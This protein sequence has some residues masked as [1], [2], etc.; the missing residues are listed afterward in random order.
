MQ[1]PITKSEYLDRNLDW[2]TVDSISL[3]GVA[4]LSSIEVYK[5]RMLD[6]KKWYEAFERNSLN[7]SF[8]G[9]TELGN[10][11]KEDASL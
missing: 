6:Q 4:R 2:S 1:N 8:E 9:K 11:I 3:D 7:S 5:L 10:H